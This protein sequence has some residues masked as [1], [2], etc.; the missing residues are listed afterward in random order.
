MD[1]ST[2]LTFP[3]SV[4]S[5]PDNQLLTLKYNVPGSD[6][7]MTCSDE[8]PLSTDSSV[9]F[10]DFLFASAPIYGVQI[11]LK[12]WTGAGSGLHLLQL[13][14]DGSSLDTSSLEYN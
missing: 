2:N 6:E 8:C 5:L 1:T 11:N 9:A 10:Q 12:A 13:L 3:L 7:T 14:S 4:T